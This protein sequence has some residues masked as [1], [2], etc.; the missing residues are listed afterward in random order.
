MRESAAYLAFSKFSIEINFTSENTEIFL[1][2]ALQPKI[3]IKM[4]H[5]EKHHWNNFFS[6]HFKI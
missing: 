2:F 1:G 6:P 4:F 5:F 3:Q